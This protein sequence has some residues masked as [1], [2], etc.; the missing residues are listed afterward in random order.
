MKERRKAVL[1][2]MSGFLCGMSFAIL[3]V[4]FNHKDIRQESPYFWSAFFVLSLAYCLKTILKGV[5]KSEQAKS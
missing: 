4:H 2:A 3:A 5:E 1:I